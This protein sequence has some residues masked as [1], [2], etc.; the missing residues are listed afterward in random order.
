[1]AGELA[2]AATPEET[3]HS[4][5]AETGTDAQQFVPHD[6]RSDVQPDACDRLQHE[7]LLPAQH[8]IAGIAAKGDTNEAHHASRRTIAVR[9]RRFMSAGS[10]IL[11]ADQ[12]EQ[13]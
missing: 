3:V 12:E 7:P 2:S 6:G 11:P 8:F 4:A 5:D 1:M 9:R 10:R 13:L